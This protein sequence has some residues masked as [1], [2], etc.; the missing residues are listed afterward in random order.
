MSLLP[1]T[2]APGGHR[3]LLRAPGLSFG[4]PGPMITSGLDTAGQDTADEGN[5]EWGPPACTAPTMASALLSFR[6]QPAGQVER[7]EIRPNG[8]LGV[9][10]SCKTHAAPT[11]FAHIFIHFTP[12]S[13]SR[14]P[15]C[16][17]QNRQVTDDNSI[18][19]T[20]TKWHSIPEPPELGL[21]SGSRVCRLVCRKSLTHLDKSMNTT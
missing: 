16:R 20:C 11:L 10:L 2:D 5:R 6:P 8:A 21:G 15:E 9:F 14:F 19:Q 17:T 13:I 7:A 3:T 1:L 12:D 4:K 18:T